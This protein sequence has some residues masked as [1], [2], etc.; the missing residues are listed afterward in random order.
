MHGKLTSMDSLYLFEL[1]LTLLVMGHLLYERRPTQTLIIWLLVVWL[2]PGVGALLY[3]LFG[4][5]KVFARRPKPQLAFMPRPPVPLKGATQRAVHDVLMADGVPPAMNGNRIDCVFSPAE[6][7]AWLFDAI[8]QAEHSIYLETYIF[9]PDETGRALLRRLVAKARSGVQV[10]LLIDTFGSLNAWL[11]RGEFAELETAGGQ[12][13]FF[14]PLSSLFRSRINLRNHRKIYLFDQRLLIS[15]GINLAAEYLD[16][17]QEGAWVDLTYRL[18]GPAVHAFLETFAQDW[19]YTTGQV[20]AF[21]HL[22]VAPA[23]EQVVQPVPS[24]P[25]IPEDSLREALLQGLY[26]AKR[27][28]DIVT[29]YFIPDEPV[30]E[31]VLLARKRGVHVRLLTPAQTDH[32]IFDLGRA[33]Y[34]RQLVEA[35]AEVLCYQPTMLHAKALII[36]R[37]LAMIG[38][39]NVDY[40]SLLINYE[41]VAFCYHRP[42]LTALR[43]TLDA[44]ARDAVPYVPPPGR[45]PRLRENLTR[46]VTPIL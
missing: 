24:G 34:M 29:P 35:G 20:V 43:D 23:G 40:R 11:R 33:P 21:D 30:L 28:V 14:Q 9:E 6:A 8:D 13:A 31:A 37:A 15:G 3:L 12:V 25:D 19:H 16:P 39:A 4:S 45:L 7:R 18:Q 5:R 38:S 26:R 41:M 27:Q 1:I 44:L 46:I 42:T 32:L 10:K 2:L 22:P 17:E 36:D